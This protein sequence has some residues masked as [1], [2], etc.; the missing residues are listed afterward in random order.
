VG[1]NV[2]TKFESFHHV[3]TVKGTYRSGLCHCH[4]EVVTLLANGICGNLAKV[5]IV[6]TKPFSDNQVFNTVF[7]LTKDLSLSYKGI[8]RMTKSCRQ[9]VNK[10][11]NPG[12][13]TQSVLLLSILEDDSLLTV[14]ERC[15]RFL[16]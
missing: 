7:I 9:R 12:K 15:F 8:L 2:N 5:Y 1:V 6:V 11:V 16:A 10:A 3:H 14:K 4:E 13:R